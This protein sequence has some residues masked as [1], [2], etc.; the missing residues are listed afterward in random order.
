MDMFVQVF[1]HHAIKTNFE[2]LLKP[3]WFESENNISKLSGHL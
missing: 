2:G 1:V 3:D